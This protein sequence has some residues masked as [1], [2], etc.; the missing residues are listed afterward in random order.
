MGIKACRICGFATLKGEDFCYRHSN[1][2]RA[3]FVKKKWEKTVGKLRDD[4][5]RRISNFE[6]QIYALLDFRPKNEFESKRQ[7]AMVKQVVAWIR[8]IRREAN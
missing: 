3:L 1:S 6:R 8:E 7:A 5:E 4:K 2:Q